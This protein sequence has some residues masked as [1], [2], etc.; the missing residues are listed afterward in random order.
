MESKTIMKELQNV[1]DFLTKQQ[2]LSIKPL[3]KEYGEDTPLFL[4]DYDDFVEKEKDTKEES[5]WDERVNIHYSQSVGIIHGYGLALAMLG[6]L[7]K[8]Y[9]EELIEIL[10]QKKPF[11]IIDDAYDYY[12]DESRNPNGNWETENALDEGEKLF[13]EKMG[14]YWSEWI[15]C[16][17]RKNK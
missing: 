17:N 4:N 9:D 16:R 5:K 7:L 2:E 6:N 3:T 8:K 10:S 11:S 12:W 1:C 15:K 14:F 13:C